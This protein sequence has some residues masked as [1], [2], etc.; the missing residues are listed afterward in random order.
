MRFFYLLLILPTAVFGHYPTT[1][2]NS[3][4][5]EEINSQDY[6][7]LKDV[8][9]WFTAAIDGRVYRNSL[10]A[11]DFYHGNGYMLNVRSEFKIED[12]Y[13]L[14]LKSL[15][16]SGSSS[17]GYEEPSTDNH[18]LGLS[19][20]YFSKF[21][22]GHLKLKTGDLGRVTLGLGIM[23]QE[24]ETNGYGAT[25]KYNDFTYQET[26]FGTSGLKGPGDLDSIEIF[27]K[28][29]LIGLSALFWSDE[30]END[31][32]MEGNLEDF[33]YEQE[34]I[35]KKDM[36]KPLVSIF[37]KYSFLPQTITYTEIST[38][39]EVFGG[40]VGFNAD[41]RMNAIKIHWGIE[42]RRYDKGFAVGFS[43]DIDHEYVTY[44]QLDKKF[45]NPINIF[46]YAD[47][48]SV[49]SATFNIEYFV[50][51][52]FVL[53]SLNEF[54]NLH[55][56]SVTKEDITWNNNYP[57]R[58]ERTFDVFFFKVGAAIYPKVKRPDLFT[59]FISNKAL[60]L[61]SKGKD[62]K[63]NLPLTHEFTYF[64]T[65]AVFSF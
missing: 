36:A 17:Y 42:Y 20:S 12:Y 6:R 62:S 11:K 37:S 25:W 27:Y 23:I 31:D 39:Y 48:V 55:F 2:K 51:D 7:K 38:R 33:S 43:N 45:S 56:G 13:T 57:T 53:Y 22:P 54:N 16:L 9:D 58:S 34:Y 8:T 40:L 44:D 64:G 4:L 63:L 65:E 59:F 50:N 10:G 52:N 1:L 26:S 35:F 29:K 32:F 30:T 60:G 3:E 47:G 49:S 14:N 28:E 61:S 5:A 15:F 19:T 18:F 24:K 46:S 21:V 41:Q